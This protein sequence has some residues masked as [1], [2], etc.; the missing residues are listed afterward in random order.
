[1]LDAAAQGLGI[2]LML[3]AHHAQAHNDQLAVLFPE[4]P[5]ESGY[6]FWFACRR[7]ALSRQA[8]RIFHDW[9]VKAIALPVP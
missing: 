9:L 7:A 1:M 8:V 2:A 5:V 3:D 4:K 6:S